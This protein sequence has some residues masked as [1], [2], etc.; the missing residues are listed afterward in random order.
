M[1]LLLVVQHDHII[2]DHMRS[3]NSRVQQSVRKHPG[4]EENTVQCIESRAS[5][6]TRKS[7]PNCQNALENM[8]EEIIENG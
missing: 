5:D 2:H 7:I 8:K 4:G 6:L 1:T 3:N